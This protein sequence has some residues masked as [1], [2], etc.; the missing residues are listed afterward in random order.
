MWRH[1]HNI[2]Q[3]KAFVCLIIKFPDFPLILSQKSEFPSFRRTDLER[4]FPWLFWKR[5]H[6]EDI[7]TEK[8]KTEQD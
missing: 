8:R 2:N 5:L 4:K 7:N 1:I 6:E 3:T